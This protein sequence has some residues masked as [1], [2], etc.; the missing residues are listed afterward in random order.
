MK[1][2]LVITQKDNNMANIYELSKLRILNNDK[3][4]Y[5][6]NQR[7]IKS[8]EYY[9]APDLRYPT[10]EEISTL[11][12]IAISWGI[13]DTLAKYAYQY[14]NTYDDWWIIAYFNKLSSEYE[15]NYGDIVYI[16]MPR[17]E[18][19]KMINRKSNI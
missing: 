8:L 3:Y 6:L 14:Y 5:L 12:L 2:F 1:D 9:T 15:L 13:G 4:I 11:N 17:D 18:I 7:G 19:Y 10:D 16:P